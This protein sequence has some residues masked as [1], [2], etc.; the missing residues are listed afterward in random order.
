MTVLTITPPLQRTPQR[1]V[2]L[3]PSLTESLFAFGL[4]DSI[5]GI[6]DYCE[7]QPQVRRKATIGGTKNPDI[8]AILRLAPDLVVANVEENRREDVG[9]LQI[10]GVPVLSAFHARSLKLSLPPEAGPDHWG[11]VAG[12]A[13]A[14]QDRS[15]VRGDQGSLSREAAG[16]ASSALS[17]DI[18][19]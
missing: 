1:I 10:H 17:G 12:V 4:G 5:V 13:S 9:R 16:Y 14:R 6:T 18:R 7:P 15:G 19:G 11:R 2:C 3:V 8:E